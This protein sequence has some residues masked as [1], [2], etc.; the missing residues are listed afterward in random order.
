MY[1]VAVIV[2]RALTILFRLVFCLVIM[3]LVFSIADGK[4]SSVLNFVKKFLYTVTEPVLA[5]VRSV[6]NR[7]FGRF[8]IQY[9]FS[10]LTVIAVISALL[11][12]F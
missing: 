10:Y 5:P 4:D 3:R 7:L 11:I 1:T 6:Q 8:A 12:I 9:D 2:R